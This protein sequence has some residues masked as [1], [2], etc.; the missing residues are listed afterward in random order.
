MLLLICPRTN[1]PL[2]SEPI[3]VVFQLVSAA[4]RLL[5]GC[6]CGQAL[7]GDRGGRAAQVR[8]QGHGKTHGLR[9]HRV[10][11]HTGQEEFDLN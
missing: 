7:P 9:R 5:R 8:G 1:W 3:F 2:L 10:L 11:L 6:A 4:H